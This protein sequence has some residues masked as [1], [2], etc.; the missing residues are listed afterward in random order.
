MARKHW[1]QMGAV[2]VKSRGLDGGI[3]SSLDRFFLFFPLS[4]RLKPAFWPTAVVVLL[5]KG[6]SVFG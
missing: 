1:G 6:Q 3:A 4:R 2:E 5:F